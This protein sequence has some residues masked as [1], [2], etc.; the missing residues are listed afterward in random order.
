MERPTGIGLYISNM[1]RGKIAQ[2]PD[3]SSKAETHRVLA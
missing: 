2:L 1:Q 3:G